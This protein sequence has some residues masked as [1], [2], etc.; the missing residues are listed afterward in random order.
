MK[1]RLVVARPVPPAV[2]ERAR[3]EYDAVLAEDRDMDLDTVLD[4]LARHRAEALFLSSNLK[5]TADVI[6]RLPETVKIAATC[7]VGYDHIDVA[8][9]KARGLVVTNTPEVLTDCTADLA[10]LLILAACRRG[11]EYEAIMRKGWRQPFGM[12]EMLGMRASGKTLGILGM[13]R[14]GQAVA[15]RARGFNMKVLYSDVRRLPPEQEHGA[16]YFADFRQMLPRC[17]ILTLHAPGGAATDRIMNRETFALLP[18]GAVFVNAARGGLVDEDALIEALRSG[19]LFA[20]GL[21]V[22]R[23]EPDFDTRLSELPN[24]FLTPHMGSAT[25][26]TRNAMGFRALDNIDAVLAGKP[27]IDPLWT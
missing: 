8:A 7:S 20:A 15:Q 2:T 13:G 24:V 3:T 9:A 10:F 6:A 12:H 22:Y 16:E 4:A 1:H 18:K 27:P 21:D 25:L 23:T 17:E 19:H 14:I 5:L 26:E 11:S